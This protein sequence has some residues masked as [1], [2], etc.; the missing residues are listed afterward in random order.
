MRDLMLD[1]ITEGEVLR[2]AVWTQLGSL[3]VLARVAWR[4]VYCCTSSACR[5]SSNEVEGDVPV[6]ARSDSHVSCLTCNAMVA[7]LVG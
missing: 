6:F 1:V 5:I 3:V 2:L 4:V 7:F